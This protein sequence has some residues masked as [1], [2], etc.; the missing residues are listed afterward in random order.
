MRKT[1]ATFEQAINE[2]Y[3]TYG[4]YPTDREITNLYYEYAKNWRLYD[5]FTD[6][7]VYYAA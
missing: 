3:A 2:Y 6:W 7:L 4:E 1:K 5:G